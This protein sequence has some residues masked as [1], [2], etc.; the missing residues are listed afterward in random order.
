MK[1]IYV[2]GANTDDLARQVNELLAE[3]GELNGTLT[4]LFH[5]RFAQAVVMPDAPKTK[6]AKPAAKS[7][8]PKSA[9]KK[10]EEV[11]ADE[12]PNPNGG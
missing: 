2:T 8:K 7:T 6:A 3:G 9:P 12:P 5:S 4:Q 1:L 10:T 11:K